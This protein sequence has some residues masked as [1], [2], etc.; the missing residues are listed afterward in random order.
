MQEYLPVL[1]DN[2]SNAYA[3]NGLGAV[4]AEL[5]RLDEAQVCWILYVYVEDNC[6]GYS[7]G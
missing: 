6:Y 4:L 7:E 3:A 1:L 2:P 5:G